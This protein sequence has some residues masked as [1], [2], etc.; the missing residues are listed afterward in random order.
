MNYHLNARDLRNR[1]TSCIWKNHR[2]YCGDSGK[3]NNISEG[4]HKNC[5][6]SSDKG[7]SYLTCGRNKRCGRNPRNKRRKVGIASCFRG[8]MM[9]LFARWFILHKGEKLVGG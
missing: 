4:C 2:G 7:S 6:V 9:V 1:L 8:S 3:C 5:A